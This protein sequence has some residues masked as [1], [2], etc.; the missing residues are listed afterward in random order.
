VI[1]PSSQRPLLDAARVLLARGYEP[2]QRLVM[3]HRRS[4]IDAMSG[5]IGELAKWTVKETNTEGPHF[6]S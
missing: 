6:V 5:K 2:E 1:L 4:S 3:R